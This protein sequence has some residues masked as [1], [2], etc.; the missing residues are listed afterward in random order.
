MVVC[1]FGSFVCL[2]VCLFVCLFVCWV[3][4]LFVC[5][6]VFVCFLCLFGSFVCLLVCLFVCLFACLLFG[7][8]LGPIFGQ[9]IG[10]ILTTQQTYAFWNYFFFLHQCLT[11]ALIS[12]Y[13]NNRWN[14]SHY[15]LF[16]WVLATATVR[17]VECVFLTARPWSHLNIAIKWS[18]LWIWTIVLQIQIFCYAGLHWRNFM[19]HTVHF[20]LN[21]RK[22][23]TTQNA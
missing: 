22:N 18:T 20:K 12:N 3:V 15:P 23:G 1:L 10:S 6:F 9:T 13:V 17:N 2:L 4:G 8:T 21:Y 7:L 16:Y 19:F 14:I 11:L 5:L